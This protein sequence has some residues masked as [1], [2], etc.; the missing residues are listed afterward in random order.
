MKFIFLNKFALYLHDTPAR[1]LFNNASRGFSHGCIRVEKP[2]DLAAYLLRDDTRRTR[3]TMSGKIENGEQE[4]ILLR[5]PIPVHI[6]YWTAWMDDQGT[7][8]FRKDIY[9]RDVPLDMA[10]KEKPPIVKRS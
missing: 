7:V 10:L 9:E 8:Q 2:M 1:E 6:L 3:E 4:A 5:N